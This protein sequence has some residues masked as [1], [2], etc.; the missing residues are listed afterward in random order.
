MNINR[1]NYEEFFTLYADNE[2]SA[3]DRKTVELF[4]AGNPDLKAEFDLL[5]T[6]KLTPD[7]TIVFGSKDALLQ[8]EPGAVIDATNYE[9][10]F[11]LY[12]DDELNNEEKAAVE[13]FVYKHPQYQADFELYQQIKYTPATAIIFEYKESLYRKEEEERRVIPI[14]WW[15]YAAAA[16]VIVLTGIFWL[17]Q[18]GPVANPIDGTQ[19]LAGTT[20][21]DNGAKTTDITATPAARDTV[22]INNPANNKLAVSATTTNS[23]ALVTIVK[24]VH[25]NIATNSNKTVPEVNEAVVAAN[26][27][28]TRVSTPEII[29]NSSIDRIANSNSTASVN[30]SINIDAPAVYLNPDANEAAETGNT[31]MYANYASDN[32][33]EV[34]NTSVSKKTP[35]RGLLRKATRLVAHR[36][37]DEGKRKGLLIGNFE[38]AMK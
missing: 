33:L 20:T 18:Q 38:I 10:F 25:N 22:V 7:T 14:R 11:V 30:G 1:H 9:M 27:I 29:N 8:A 26:D 3:T 32:K 36:T 2:L 5:D 13:Q 35:L 31:N 16:A 24:S 17:L 23:N 15:R 12:A 34:L 4:V 6:F 21:I 19:T 37:D 28:K